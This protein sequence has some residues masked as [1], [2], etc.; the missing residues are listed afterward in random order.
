MEIKELRVRKSIP[1]KKNQE[2]YFYFQQFIE[3]LQKRDL[4]GKIISSVNAS[5]EEINGIPSVEKNLGREIKQ[6]QKR[7]VKLVEK[8]L[9]IV[10]RNYYQNIW[11]VYGMAFFGLPI[12]FGFTAMLGNFGLL[13]F[14]L[15]TGMALGLAIGVSVGKHL[16]K[17]ALEEGRQLD[18]ELRL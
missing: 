12:G 18:A 5:V 11:L 17:K 6:H 2:A 14:G 13:T 4:P 7:I 15:G 1:G 16:D 9:K 10:P 8:E 3:E